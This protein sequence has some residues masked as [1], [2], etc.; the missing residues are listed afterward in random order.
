MTDVFGG[1]PRPGPA[2]RTLK[3]LHYMYLFILNCG[4]LTIYTRK[5]L[6]HP[7]RTIFTCAR[8]WCFEW[9][10]GERE[11]AQPSAH[12]FAVARLATASHVRDALQAQSE[13]TAR[14]VSGGPRRGKSHRAR[15]VPVDR[16]PREARTRWGLGLHAWPPG[17][18]K[19]PGA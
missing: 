18:R 6:P 4:I 12:S 11:N 16:G 10:E 2:K 14:G 13:R 3:L 17:A 19:M 8:V 5:Q 15:C 7:T 1:R 9:G